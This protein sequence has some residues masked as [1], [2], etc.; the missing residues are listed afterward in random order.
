MPKEKF[1]VIDANSI[2]NRAF[3]GIRLLTAKDGTYTNAVYGFLNIFYKYKEEIK[4]DYIA[5]AFDLKAPT[6][7]HKMFDG[8]KATRRPMPA[9]LVPQLPL[10]KE[11]LSALSIPILEKEGYEADDIIGTVAA[12]CSAR[13]VACCI[14]TGDKDDLQL[15]TEDNRIYLITTRMGNTDTE[16][17]DAQHVFEKYGVTPREFID[18]KAIMGDTSDNIPGVKGIGE[19]GALAL[20]SEFKSL[21][22][23]YENI[24]APSITKSVRTKLTDSR[25]TA[26]LSK[27]LATIDCA[28]PIELDFAAAK[29]EPGNTEALRA[30]YT[31]LEFK[32]F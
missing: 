18:V 11:V 23:V 14:L 24:D 22:A 2:I 27:T 13:D 6:F 20:I 4:P 1:L 5:A 16:I 28:V 10:L 19:K 30:L 32:S 31:R 25:E 3:Y 8:Y 17:F 15:A 26:F 12:Q 29:D 21:E 9:E 7:R